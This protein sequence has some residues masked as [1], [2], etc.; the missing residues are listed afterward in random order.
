M[1]PGS[2]DALF[3]HSEKNWVS[4]S[5]SEAAKGNGAVEL[6]L[7]FV[8]NGGDLTGSSRAPNEEA[9]ASPHTE[10]AGVL[11]HHLAGIIHGY[12]KHIIP[13]FPIGHLTQI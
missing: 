7:L 4:N 5:I 6:I 13:E 2:D 1:H 8:C 10:S 9:K 11:M 12:C 3:Y